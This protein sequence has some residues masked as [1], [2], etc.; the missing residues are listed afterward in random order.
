M[1]SFHILL[2]LASLALANTHA[3]TSY[4][5]TVLADQPVAYWTMGQPPGSTYAA[6]ASGHGNPAIV[7]G[8]VYFGQRGAL[9][10]DPTTSVGLLG[11]GD[12]VT[13]LDQTEVSQYSL[14]AWVLTLANIAPILQDRGFSDV[15][16]AAAMSITLTIGQ[17]DA[18][19]GTVHC[20]L[21]ADYLSIGD[22]T[23]KLVDDG[24]WH[25]VVCVF[26]GLAGQAITPSQFTIYIDGRPQ[27]VVPFSTGS[28]TAPVS[29][30]EG[31]TIGVHPIWEQQFGM[32]E[33]S[34]LLTEVA[35]YRHALS[36]AR[37]LAHYEAAKCPLTCE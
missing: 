28:A 9:Q 14:E 17:P 34:G 7:Q 23:N 3:Q 4:E 2:L 21:D 25:H 5:A 11:N 32:P 13:P 30:N 20:G 12:F 24:K 16:D 1:T 10:D 36:A 15:N 19:D 22:K 33:Y 35:V 27:P 8:S 18:S 31:T 6:D 26:S 29:G 37:V